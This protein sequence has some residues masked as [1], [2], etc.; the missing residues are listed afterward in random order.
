MKKKIDKAIFNALENNSK[1]LGICLGM[2]LLF[3]HSEEDD[4]EG[5]KLIDGRIKKF[6]FN[7]EI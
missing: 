6:N 5:L 1:F 4:C 3:N 2:A 7:K